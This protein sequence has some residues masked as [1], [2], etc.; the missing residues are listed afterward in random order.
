ME[1]SAMSAGPSTARG[2]RRWSKIIAGQLALL[3]A[4]LVALELGARA[5]L[6]MR[7]D[8]YHADETRRE[9]RQLLDLT[10][11]LIPRSDRDRTDATAESADTDR[12]DESFLHPYLGWEM[13][14]GIAQL[15]QEYKRLR[16]G[17]CAGEMQIWLVGGSVAA[18]F[19]WDLK[20]WG[21]VEAALRADPNLAGRKLH[22]V[23]LARAGF[24]EPQQ[25]NFVLYMLGLGFKPAAIVNID[26][27]NEVALGN[28][29]KAEGS[30]PVFPSAAHWAHLAAWGTGDRG[31]I[32]R[33][34]EIRSTQST[35]ETWASLIL[36]RH[37][38]H[39]AVIGKLVLHRTYHLWRILVEQFDAYSR[40]LSDRDNGV[41]MHGPWLD[42]GEVEAVAASV[43]CWKESSRCLSDLCRGRGIAYIHVLQPTLH[44][45]GSKPLTAKEI[46]NS[47]V[48]QPWIDGAKLGYP[49]M[50][51]EADELRRRG[52]DFI[53]ASMIFSARMDDLYFDCCHFSPAGNEILADA[54]APEIA[55]RLS[56]MK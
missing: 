54:I 39:S 49:L 6:W 50:R 48:A 34:A 27:F 53:D 3:I 42:G 9:A 13:E 38:E 23:V 33:V 41:S 35:I 24:K 40:Y 32:D 16:R 11:G 44:D 4:G 12:G 5:W 29:N 10:R 36:N 26:G 52:V 51:K 31:A 20:G 22:S 8:A 17:E 14:S 46:E 56:E 7:G 19:G 55:K 43:R 2:A 45:A 21:R 47:K 30:H 37:A 28:N 18:R 1:T 25:L 15:D